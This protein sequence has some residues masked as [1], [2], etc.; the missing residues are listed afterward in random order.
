MKQI[1]LLLMTS[2]YVNFLI[3]N[4]TKN[5]TYFN[6][7]LSTDNEKMIETASLINLNTWPSKMHEIDFSR[8]QLRE[9]WVL[10]LSIMLKIFKFEK[11]ERTNIGLSLISHW[12]NVLIVY[13]IAINFISL[14]EA[15]VFSL[16]YLSSAWTYQVALYLG[17]VIFSQT[18]ALIS[19]LLLIYHFKF[20]EIFYLFFSAICIALSFL[21]PPHLASTPIF[22]YRY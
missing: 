18:W 12:F 21:V 5:I 8:G 14:N 7:K 2:T 9:V 11:S 15:V 1:F 20:T 19:I 22:G 3:Y 6:K 13:Q 17:H 16:I 10:A 4:K